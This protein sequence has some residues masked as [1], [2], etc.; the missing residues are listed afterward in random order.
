[1]MDLGERAG[2]FKFLILD[3]D[4]K[5]ITAFDDVFTRERHAGD[6]DTSP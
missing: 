1:M 5:F 2:Q 6:Q 3:R 4:G